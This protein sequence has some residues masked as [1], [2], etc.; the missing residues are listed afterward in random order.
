MCLIIINCIV[1]V[2][3]QQC[4]KE[5]ASG[6]FI[7]V[8]SVVQLRW[9]GLPNHFKELY[10]YHLR[11][12][13]ADMHVVQVIVVTQARVR[14]LICTHD[15]RGR[16]A[17]EGECGH[18]RQRTSSCVATNMLH[19]RHSKNLPKLDSNISASLYSNG[20]SL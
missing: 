1:L 19:F 13:K 2:N 8:V 14:C 3:G 15:A 16:A 10:S 17:P 18:I 4:I 9:V 20:Y 5:S 6:W 12:C 7:S 11:Y